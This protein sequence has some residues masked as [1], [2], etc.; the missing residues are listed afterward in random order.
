[1]EEAHLTYST[2]PANT[3]LDHFMHFLKCNAENTKV[4]NK[5]PKNLFFK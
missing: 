4:W 2:K 3:N 1:V 5:K